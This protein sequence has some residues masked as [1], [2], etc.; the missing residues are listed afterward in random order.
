M[1]RPLARLPRLGFLGIGWIGR[2]RLQKVAASGM[3]EITAIA[4]TDTA[5]LAAAAEDAPQAHACTSLEQLL[6]LDLDGIVIATPSAQHAEQAIQALEAGRAV[7]CQ[8]PLG[9]DAAEVQ[10]VVAAARRADR[11]LGVD[12]CYRHLAG[13]AELRRRIQAGALGH[14]FAGRLVFHN[15]YGPDKPWFYDR[16][17]AGGG[18]LMDLGIHLIDLALWLFDFP[19][20]EHAQGRCFARGKPLP[21]PPE[22]VEDYALARLDLANGMSLELACSWKLAAGQD[23]DIQA[24][25][26]GTGGGAT[27]RNVNGSFFDFVLEWNHGTARERLAGPPDDWGGRAALAWVQALA[28]DGR[29][30]EGAR[31]LIHIAE[32]IDSIYA[33][34]YRASAAERSLP[35]MVR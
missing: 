20:V 21:S 15:A 27:L 25:F 6:E 18:C 9:R 29:F 28:A 14:P 11:L 30:D 3:A 2:H 19:E 32:V 26:Y 5:A 13:M 24:S 17:L 34:D 10:A 1:N 16:N 23:A 7:F 12:F 8:K 22:A 31:R 35:A 33:R 4:D